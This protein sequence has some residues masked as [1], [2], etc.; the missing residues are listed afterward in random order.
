L[1]P[2]YI[3]AYNDI[4]DYE[5]DPAKAESNFTKHG[6]HLADAVTVLEDDSALT[7]R[8]SFSEEEERWVTLGMD[9]LGRILVVVYIWRNEKIRL[10]SARVATPQ[11]RLQYTS[12]WNPPEQ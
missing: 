8:D 1:T 4:V 3:C 9:L 10:I 12:N 7:I 2:V 11:E 5:W 6:I